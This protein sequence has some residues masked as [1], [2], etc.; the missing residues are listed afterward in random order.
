MRRNCKQ[1]DKL[2]RVAEHPKGIAGE[3]YHRSVIISVL[4][5]L[6]WFGVMLCG[7]RRTN[8]FLPAGWVCAEGK[9][10]EQKNIDCDRGAMNIVRAEGCRL[11]AANRWWCGELNEGG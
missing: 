5:L 4:L 1:H 11:N 9:E 8:T 3:Q 7:R 2:R 10:A 6:Q